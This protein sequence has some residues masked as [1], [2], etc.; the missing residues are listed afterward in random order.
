MIGRQILRLDEACEA[1][2]RDPASLARL[3]LTGPQLDPG[4]AS[5][6]AFE[7]AKLAYAAV[8]VTDLV[9]HWPRP[10]EPYAGDPSIL[11]GIVT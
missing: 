2:G 3:V 8:G 9:V 7:E 11:E 4:L 5:R 1:T 6:A 10:S